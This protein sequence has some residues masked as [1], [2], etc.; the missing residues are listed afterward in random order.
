[1]TKQAGIAPPERLVLALRRHISSAQLAQYRLPLTPEIRLW[2]LDDAFEHQNLDAETVSAL[3]DEPPYWTFCWASGQVLARYI[4][5]HAQDFKGRTVV[6]VGSG[7]GVVA[8]A[9]ALAGAAQV[10]AC[11]IDPQALAVVAENAALN[12]VTVAL[13]ANLEESLALAD[14]VSAADILYDRGNLPLLQHFRGAADVLLADSRIKNLDQDGYA[15]I[16]TQTST[17]WPDL[18]ESQEFNQVRIYRACSQAR[19][20]RAT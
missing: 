16:G 5:D 4:L 9:A 14:I 7:S 6:D 3:M 10:I 15:L 12:N 18:A 13:S 19:D 2:L 1:M 20:Q 17:T 8:I 11:D